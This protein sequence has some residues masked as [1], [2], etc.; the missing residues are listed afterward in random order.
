MYEW[1]HETII[2]TRIIARWQKVYERK[3]VYEWQACK[4]KKVYKWKV[5]E[6]KGYKWKNVSKW[7]VYELKLKYNEN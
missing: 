4:W 2:Q 1:K 5:Y 6:W 3:K 7:K